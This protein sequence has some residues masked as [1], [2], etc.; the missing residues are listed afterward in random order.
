MKGSLVIVALFVAGVIAG[1]TGIAAIP[2][3]LDVSFYVLCALIFFVGMSIGSDTDTLRSF[4]SLNPRLFAL[5]VLTI[6]GTLAGSAFAALILPHSTADCM[7][8]GSGMAYYSLSSVL[9]T[10]SRGAD[11]GVVA[12]LANVLREIFTLL[13]APLLARYV[14]PLAPIAAGGATTAD[15]TLPIITTATGSGYVPLSIAHGFICDFSVPFLVSFFCS[16]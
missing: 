3:E 1:A 8:V 15:T 9:I 16:I 6:L 13:L 2:E 12:L 5:P 14:N 4:K 7:A 11:L 10:E